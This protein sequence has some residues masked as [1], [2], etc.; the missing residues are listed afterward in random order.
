MGIHGVY[1]YSYFQNS[2]HTGEV[3]KVDSIE[4]VKEIAERNNVQELTQKSEEHDTKKQDWHPVRLNEIS[5]NFQKNNDY[6]YIG[7]DSNLENLDIQKVI[8]DMKQDTILQDY[9]YFVGNAKNIYQSEDGT[10][11]KK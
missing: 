10:V 5:L 8:S 7:R 3:P 9:T 2:Y 6:S 1:P 4:P 11:I